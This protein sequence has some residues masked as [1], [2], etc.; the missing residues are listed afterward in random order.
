M[1]ICYLLARTYEGLYVYINIYFRF[2]IV[3]FCYNTRLL[4][5][6]HKHNLIVMAKL[7]NL[8]IYTGKYMIQ[9]NI[10]CVFS[11]SFNDRQNKPEVLGIDSLSL[12]YISSSDLDFYLIQIICMF[13][14]NI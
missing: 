12:W 8:Y 10:W 11:T 9:D 3:T 4:K 1:F 13:M 2:V 6:L 7:H 14:C 5:K